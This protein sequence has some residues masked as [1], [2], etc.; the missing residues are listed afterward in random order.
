MKVK[1]SYLSRKLSLWVLIFLDIVKIIKFQKEQNNPSTLTVVCP[2]G[3]PLNFFSINLLISWLINVKVVHIAEILW[4]EQS[5]IN[6]DYVS[7]G[8]LLAKKLLSLEEK[9]SHF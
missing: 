5:F 8:V 2:Y 9:K 4:S 1:I 3:M 6:K 7:L